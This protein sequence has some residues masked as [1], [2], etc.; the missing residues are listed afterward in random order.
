VPILVGGTLRRAAPGRGHPVRTATGEVLAYATSAAGADVVDAVAAARAAQ[1]GWAGAA[2]LHRGRVL[3]GVAELLDERRDRFAAEIR[4][5]DDVPA[6]RA[7]ELVD[8]A[9]DRWVWYAGWTDK[10]AGVL[11]SVNA[12]AGPYL[13]WSA[14]RP[15]GV[16]G[17]VAPDGS[18]PP[19][20][21]LLALVDVLAPVLAVGAT[22]I[23]VA[24]QERPQLA[25][26]LSEVLALAELPAGAA[27]LL[28]GDVPA[29]VA[30]LTAAG[31]DGLDLAGAAEPTS[32]S[33]PARVLRPAA[34]PTDGLARL[35]A[36]TQVTTVWHP[37]G[38]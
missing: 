15:V 10:I 7:A 37:L 16:V 9:V 5:V 3:H 13:S 31:V 30:N 22:A 4:A 24:T 18:S 35:R 29:L 2:P 25:G 33:S 38:R 11:G 34:A 20:S 19:G 8:A 1:P 36:W 14:P 21:G 6:E 32:V 23:V 28:T 17:A 26:V 27:S 12:V